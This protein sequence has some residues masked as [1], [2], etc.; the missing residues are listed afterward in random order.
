MIDVACIGNLVADVITKPVDNVPGAGLLERVESIEVFSGGCAMNAGVDM[1][2]IGIKTAVLGKVGKD[3][4]GTFLKE[5]LI[6]YGVDVSGLVFDE[7]TQTSAS[8]VLSSSSGERSFLHCVGA[9]GTYGYEDVDFDVIKKA[10]IVFVAGTMLLDRFDGEPCAKTLKKAR[11]MGKMTVLDTA[12]DSKGR[13]MALLEPCLKYVD[14]FMPSVDEAAKLAGTEDLDNIA[15]CFFDNGVKHVVIKN[16][17]YGAYLRTAKDAKPVYLPTYT[18]EK[19]ID[20]TGAGDSFCAG[21][22]TGLAK[23]FSFEECGKLANA[24]GTFCVMAKGASTGIK[25]YEEICKYMQTHAAG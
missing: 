15:D 14:V 23:G 8:V 2:K 22:L 16:G 13:W 18:K 24:V 5:E 19:V 10:K 25:S 9:N 17:K 4:F 1:A 12:W 7:H 6:K 21:F 11:E 20:T 3:S